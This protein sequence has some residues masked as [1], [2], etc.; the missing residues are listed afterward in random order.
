MSSD[1]RKS[2]DEYAFDYD[3]ALRRGLSVTGE[4]KSYFARRRIEWLRDRLLTYGARIDKIMDYGCGTGSS[5]HLL[6]SILGARELVGT[7]TSGSLLKIANSKYSS[8]SVKFLLFDEYQPDGML[9]LVYCNGVFHHIPLSERVAAVNYIYRSIRPGGFFAFWENNPWNPGTR[10][11]MNRVSFDKDAVT[12]SAPSGR[13]LLRSGGFEILQTD[14]LFIFPNV[15]RWLRWI[16]TPCAA[17]PLGG[18][19]QVL[20]RRPTAS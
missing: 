2:F 19:Y 4:N 18:Q 7:D 20:C 12:L 16:E 8:E 5:A 6:I 17:L 1:F 9:D 13:A 10:L 11:I 15:L 14:F 3:A